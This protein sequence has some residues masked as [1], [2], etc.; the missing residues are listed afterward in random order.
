MR[1]VTFVFCCCLLT[2]IST[3]GAGSGIEIRD[4]WIAAAPPGVTVQAAYMQLRNT[5]N[6]TVVLTKIESLDFERVELH[7]SVM[8]DGMASMRHLE[9]YKFHEN[10]TLEMTPGGY[11]LMLFKPKRRLQ[12]GDTSELRFSFNNGEQLAISA[13]VR[14]HTP[15]HVHHH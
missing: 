2:G 7:Q 10:H 3:A 14:K 6:S 8:D 11:H 4:P 1:Y 12:E 5:G 13:P 15:D 9:N